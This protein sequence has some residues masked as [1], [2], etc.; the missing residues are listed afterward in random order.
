MKLA[1][2][3]YLTTCNAD[4]IMKICDHHCFHWGQE[5]SIP[6]K[7]TLQHTKC[8]LIYEG[9]VSHEH[10]KNVSVKILV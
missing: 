10:S 2:Y 8:F 4:T 1:H 3:S 9:P 7:Q 5:D 6:S